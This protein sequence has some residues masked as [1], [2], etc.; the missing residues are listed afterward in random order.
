TIVRP[1]DEST[2]C[3]SRKKVGEE[4]SQRP[5]CTQRSTPSTLRPCRVSGAEGL[6][7]VVT[8]CAIGLDRSDEA[9]GIQDTPWGEALLEA[10]HE[11]E[12]RPG[13]IPHRHAL[14]DR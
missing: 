13:G 4:A 5:Q 12:R 6:G 10:L 1:L 11:A 14:L 7:S 8:G 2:A 9:T 3:P